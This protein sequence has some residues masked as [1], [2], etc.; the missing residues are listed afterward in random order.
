[1]S[2]LPKLATQ[3]PA[4]LL[5][6]VASPFFSACQPELGE[7][8]TAEANRLA[9]Y[10]AQGSPQTGVPAYEGQAL[11][12]QACGNGFCHS[13]AAEGQARYGVPGGFDFDVSLACELGDDGQ[14]PDGLR[15]NYDRLSGNSEDVF[16]H[17]RSILAEVEAGTMPPPGSASDDVRAQGGQY[18]RAGSAGMFDPLSG[19]DQPLPEIGTAAGQEILRNWLACGAPVIGATRKPEGREPGESCG[20]MV[21]VGQCFVRYDP[22]PPP[23]PNWDSIYSFFS[24]NNCVTGCHDSTAASLDVYDESSLDLH[25]KD[26]AYMELLGAAEGVSCGGDGNLVVAG[27]P[28]ASL[29]IQK[30]EM[31]NPACG[32]G[33]MP[34]GRP[35][36]PEAYVAPIRAW[37]AAGAP[38]TEM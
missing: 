13:P 32:G 9:Y 28:D 27:D 4:V 26:I 21:D 6:F 17:A 33:S 1:M 24:G 2:A 12:L 7:C 20:V 18:F 5:V 34:S 11:V 37:I 15:P 19:G 14:C 16:D 29:L 38:E 31:E 10:F 22:P 23:E 8:N 25:D 36:L 3:V 35:L 30:I